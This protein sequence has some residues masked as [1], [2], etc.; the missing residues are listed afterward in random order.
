MPFVPPLAITNVP[1]RVTSPPVKVLGVNPV[2]PALKRVTDTL[3][4]FT[5]LGAEAPFD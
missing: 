5:Q 1:P 2:V 3:P 4:A